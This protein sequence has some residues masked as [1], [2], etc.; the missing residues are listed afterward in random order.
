LLIFDVAPASNCEPGRT[1]N[2]KNNGVSCKSKH[3]KPVI[4]SDQLII[5]KSIDI[6]SSPS[7]VWHV[8]TT[9]EMITQYFTGA[10]TATT[11]EPGSEITFTHIYE[12]KELKNKGIILNFEPNHLLRYTYWTSFSN[13]ED[14]PEN[15]TTITYILEEINSKTRLNLAQ[16]NFQNIEWYQALQVGWDQVLQKMKELAEGISYR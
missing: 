15:Y 7:R 4:L 8:L 10:K 6:Y 1:D 2:Y 9:A 13:T 3:D 16:S 11:W 12:G 5:S 14:K